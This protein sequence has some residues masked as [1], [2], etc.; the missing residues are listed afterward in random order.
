MNDGLKQRIVGAL[1]LM[2][3]G[4]IFVPVIFDK[5]RI[6]PVDRSSH[7]P[8]EPDIHVLPLPEAP[9][10]SHVRDDS[11]SEPI[12]GQFS[13]DETNTAVDVESVND[14][15]EAAL[16]DESSVETKTVDTSD[17]PVNNAQLWVLQIASYSTSDKANSI[18]KELEAEGYKSLVR[19]AGAHY[20]VYVGPSMEKSTL[21]SA[22]LKL[23]SH[24]G[25]NAMLVRYTP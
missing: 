11:I 24:Y 15:V 25:V 8:P 1:V 9:P 10:V 6:V 20:R 5:E 23:D 18:R 17:R 14:I 19:Q 12:R 4:I 21:E 13:I 7:I 3:L 2:A 22:K 16:P